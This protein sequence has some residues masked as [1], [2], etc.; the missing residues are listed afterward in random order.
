[1]SAARLGLT[2]AVLVAVLGQVAVLAPGT[3]GAASE[4]DDLTHL[5]PPPQPPLAVIGPE[6]IGVLRDHFNALADR[7]RMLL[8]LSPT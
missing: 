3:G 1:L 8:L 4:P 5:T 6:S 7:T 2:A